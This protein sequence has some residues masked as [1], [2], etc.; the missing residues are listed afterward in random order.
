MAR[1]SR[2]G[3][4]RR[5]AWR[6]ALYAALL[7][8]GAAVLAVAVL[9]SLRGRELAGDLLRA[10]LDRF[11]VATQSLEIRSVGLGSI[12]LGAIHLGTSEG[13]SAAAVIVDWSPRSLRHGELGR[14]RIEGLR[15]TL[16]LDHGALAIAGLPLA[17]ATSTSGAPVPPFEQI[18]LVGA[19][20]AFAGPATATAELDATITAGAGGGVSGWATIDG[21]VTTEGGAPTRIVADLP[22][23]HLVND[24]RRVQLAVARATL[25]LPARN[26]VLA[27]VAASVLLAGDIDSLSLDG[28]LRDETVP[29]AWPSLA[30]TLEGRR[31]PG[32]GGDALVVAGRGETPDHALVVTLDGRH[33]LA[34]GHGSLTLHTA[35][36][37]F[38]PDG[39]QPADLFPAIGD[40]VGRVTGSLAA[41]ATA[42]WGGKALAT[43]LVLSLDRIGFDGGLATVSN[44][45]GKVSFDALVPP[46]TPDAQH[47]TGL[48]RIASLPAAPFD[49][50]FALPGRDRLLVDRAT[51][52]LA[53]GALSLNGVTLQHGQ[54]LAATL[55]IRAVDI[56]TVLTLI[57]IDGLSGSGALDGSIPIRV[58]PA[59][60]TIEGGRLEATGP[61]FVRYTGAG[62]PAAITQAQG[63]SGDAL[64]LT[65]EALA[66]FH[67]AALT[68]TLDRAASGDGS[69]LVALKGNNPAVL[70]GHPFDINIRLDA[71]FDRLAAIFL[72][73]Y[74]AADGLLRKAAGQ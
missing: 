11:G 44:L 7:V 38:R 14:M 54:P 43:T 28:T 52:D 24:G 27:D 65:R 56:A 40:T 22:D 23:W 1:R 17:G 10:A 31:D 6:S 25:R 20:L 70:D 71:N 35:P 30:L 60:V 4:A 69:L 18:D 2:T 36:V 48:L 15:L 63:P 57:G 37:T 8:I 9:A 53:G 58:D 47:L 29:P 21:A 59:G 41:V 66:D 13:P 12:A 33:D 74:E 61:G 45:G 5:R 64:R 67:Y 55:D 49:L 68:L 50:R 72:S 16:R 73:G 51:L 39:R 34:S 32:A 19:H 46:H 62:L 26:A 42:S 3:R